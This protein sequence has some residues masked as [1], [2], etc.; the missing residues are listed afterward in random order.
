M[1]IAMS[2]TMIIHCNTKEKVI[3][4]KITVFVVYVLQFESLSIQKVLREVY[5]EENIGV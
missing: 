2:M 4:K 5:G 3:K 1:H